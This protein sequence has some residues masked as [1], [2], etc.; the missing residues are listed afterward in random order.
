LTPTGFAFPQN[1]AWQDS[2]KSGDKEEVD[3]IEMPQS[4]VMRMRKS[5]QEG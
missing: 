1:N 3:G 5:L 2:R 4:K